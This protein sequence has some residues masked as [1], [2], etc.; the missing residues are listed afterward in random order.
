[1]SALAIGRGIPL[2]RL[3]RVG[4]SSGRTR[5]VVRGLVGIIAFVVLWELGTQADPWFGIAVPIVGGLPGPADVASQFVSLAGTAGF[6]QSCLA[7]LQRV[8]VGFVAALAVGVPLGL[9]MATRPTVKAIL[10]PPFEV[11]RPIPPLAWVP[12]AILFWP[13]DDLSIEFVIFLGAVY[14]IVLN[15]VGAA[16]L[17]DRRH[18]LVARSLGAHGIGL[19]R[20]VIIPATLPSIAT[21]AVVGVGITWEVVVAAELIAGG[22]QSNTSGGVGFL[23]WNAYQGNQVPDV[24][25]CMIVLGVAGYASSAVLR[26]VADRLM[27][28]RRGR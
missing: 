10:F 7:S 2:V 9:L 24:I 17:L 26:L 11:L 28:W 20:R 15:I 6:W 8:S 23:L 14:P 12:L 3:R 19:F 21:G 27:P 13:T 1:M 5:A 25:V 22:G 4:L 18:L 16:E